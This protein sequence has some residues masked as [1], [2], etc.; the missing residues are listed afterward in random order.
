MLF[1]SVLKVAVLT[2]IAMLWH[3]FVQKGT[4]GKWAGAIELVLWILV[5][6][7]AVAFLLTNVS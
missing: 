4:K 2:P 3:L 5:V 7:A 1:R 6:S